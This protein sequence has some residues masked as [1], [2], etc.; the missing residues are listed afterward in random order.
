MKKKII[1]FVCLTI[2][3]LSALESPRR[4]ESPTAE[5]EYV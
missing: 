2:S 3:S 1:V 5:E 4:L